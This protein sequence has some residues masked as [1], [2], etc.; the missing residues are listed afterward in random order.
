MRSAHTHHY[1]AKAHHRTLAFYEMPLFRQQQLSRYARINKE[2]LV[3]IDLVGNIV[4][5]VDLSSKSI[6]KTAEDYH[7]AD[8]AFVNIAALKTATNDLVPS[9]DIITKA[10][11]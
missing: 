6:L 1:K 4:Q 3:A 7:P 5:V 8:G 11:S 10:S 2:T 9:D